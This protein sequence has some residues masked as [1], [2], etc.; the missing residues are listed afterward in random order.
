MN[1]LILQLAE[2][3]LKRFWSKVDVRGADEC[4][5]WLG[6][7][8]TEQRTGEKTYGLLRFGRKQLLSNQIAAF[9]SKGQPEPID[10]FACH[11]CDNPPCCNGLHLFW[12]TNGD[13]L[14]DLGLKGKTGAQLH[15]EI[16][17]GERNGFSKLTERQIKEIRASI[18]CNADL[19]RQ[20]EVSRSVI[21]K[22][23]KNQI[24]RHVA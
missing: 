11:T 17:R 1:A 4:W 10:L 6:H 24:W 23:R 19:G 21:S 2:S 13:N 3:D 15:P 22:I 5:P 7:Q 20:Y 12:G 9:L 14:Y 18:L 8:K 16:R